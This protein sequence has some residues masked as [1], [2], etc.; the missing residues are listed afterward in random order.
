MQDE[1]QH[2]HSLSKVLFGEVFW[3]G[4]C[5]GVIGWFRLSSYLRNRVC[6]FTERLPGSREISEFLDGA[7]W[8]LGLRLHGLLV[9]IQ[10][11]HIPQKIRIK[12]YKINDVKLVEDD[13]GIQ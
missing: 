7:W 3:Q 6:P 4:K 1:R 11:D 13:A 9:D 8:T 12:L 2:L 10:C 5:I